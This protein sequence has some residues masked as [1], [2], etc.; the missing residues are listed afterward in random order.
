MRSKLDQNPYQKGI[1]ISDAQLKPVQLQKINFLGRM[2]LQDHPRE[3]TSYSM[4][5][6]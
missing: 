3:L 1:K 5:A 4:T 2:E 6:H